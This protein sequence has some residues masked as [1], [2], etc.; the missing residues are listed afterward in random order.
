MRVL[1]VMNYYQ[2]SSP[3][4]QHTAVAAERR[5]LEEHGHEVSVFAADNDD[6]ASQSLPRLALSL[7]PR[8]VWSQQSY[9]RLLRHLRENPC[10]L[11]HVHETFPK[12]SPSIYYA[13]AKARLPIVQTWHNFRLACTGGIFFRNGA[14]C[15]ECLDQCHVRGFWHGCYRSSLF[16]LPVSLMLGLHQALK[17][18]ARLLDASIALSP[19][20]RDLLI[21]SGLPAERVFLCP[22]FTFAPDPAP[23]GARR[24]FVFAG[25]LDEF[26]GTRVLAQAVSQTPDLPYTIIGSGP[27]QAMLAATRHPQLT[28]T[29]FL[30]HEQVRPYLE[31]AKALVFPSLVFENGPLAVI[32]A[33]AAGLPVVASDLGAMHDMIRH[34][35]NGLLVPAGDATALAAALTRLEADPALCARLSIGA[36]QTFEQR[37]SPE[38]AYRARRA[39]Y[40][41]ALLRRAEKNAARPV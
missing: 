30:P 35:E 7:G 26:K 13:A 25:R 19:N 41:Y 23:Q 2:A 5:L 17:S 37:Y 14:P 18:H 10:D 38:V 29:G 8:V 20:S 16:S 24:G 9:R 39:V 40:E 21:R 28:L 36:R 27:L 31:K 3:N 1:L 34:E 15:T 33:F 22:N 6:L 32:E 4:G 12:L 11:V